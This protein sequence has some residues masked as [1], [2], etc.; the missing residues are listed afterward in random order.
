M[1]KMVKFLK[2]RAT[3]MNRVIKNLI[4][5]T[6]LGT[7]SWAGLASAQGK[8]GHQLQTKCRVLNQPQHYAIVTDR[9]FQVIHRNVAKNFVQVRGKLGG[10][11]GNIISYTVNGFKIKK[12]CPRQS[13]LSGNVF[14]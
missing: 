5:I 3:P 9:T 10:H 8:T 13:G 7:L 4:A 14:L 6:T 2:C 11:D 12:I 1:V